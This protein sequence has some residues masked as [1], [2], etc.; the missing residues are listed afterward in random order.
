MLSLAKQRGYQP[1]TALS[2]ELRRIANTPREREREKGVWTT[3][4][5]ASWLASAG[6]QRAER[7]RAQGRHT[8]NQ[9]RH[10][11]TQEGVGGSSHPQNG[12]CAR[13]T[14]HKYVRATPLRAVS[15]LSCTLPPCPPPPPTSSCFASSRS[16][17]PTLCPRLSSSSSS[18]SPDLAQP[19]ERG[20]RV[21]SERPRHRL[22]ATS[23]IEPSWKRTVVVPHRRNQ[24]TLFSQLCGSFSSVVASRVSVT[25]VRATRDTSSIF[26]Q[27]ED[28]TKKEETRTWN[29][30]SSFVRISFD[31]DQGRSV[32][33]KLKWYCFCILEQYSSSLAKQ[34]FFEGEF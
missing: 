34:A 1:T 15:P 21:T 11:E 33:S 14:R 9:H 4:Y 2:Q 28:G 13:R 6:W 25:L 3:H 5:Q 23:V 22:R 8:S 32:G 26:E 10:E 20:A 12:C 29:W 7:K 27:L 18:S 17:I 16:T 31:S 24:A 19:R 30:I